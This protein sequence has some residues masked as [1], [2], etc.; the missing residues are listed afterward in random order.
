MKVIFTSNGDLI[1]KQNEGLYETYFVKTSGSS[2][3][4][5]EEINK[6][7]SDP[8]C[9]EDDF[10]FPTKIMKQISIYR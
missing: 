3:S 9:R 6:V 7:I 10:Y 8:F 1:L 4:F 5:E 2:S